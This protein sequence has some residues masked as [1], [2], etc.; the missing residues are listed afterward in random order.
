MMPEESYIFKKSSTEITNELQDY[1]YV[2]GVR[3]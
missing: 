3:T 2:I 1:M